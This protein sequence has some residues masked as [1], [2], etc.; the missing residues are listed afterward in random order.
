ML[1]LA[2]HVTRLQYFIRSQRSACAKSSFRVAMWKQRLV[3]KEYRWTKSKFC[4]ALDNKL[5]VRTKARTD[6]TKDLVVEYKTDPE[7]GKGGFRIEIPGLMSAGRSN[8]T[9]MFLL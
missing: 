5:D 3:R 1:E 7:G 2:L 9:R 4:T 8:S 6:G